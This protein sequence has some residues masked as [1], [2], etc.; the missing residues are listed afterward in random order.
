MKK[1]IIVVTF[2]IISSPAFAQDVNAQITDYFPLDIGN[3]WTYASASGKMAEIIIIR[4]SMDDNVSN[5]GTSIYLFEQ[6][7]VGIGS[8]TTLYS[9]KQ[10]KVVIMVERNIFGQYQ[11]K[12]P[13][14]PVLALAGQEWQYNDR[15]DD[16][17]Y[18]T[19]K[20]SCVFDGK[21]FNDCILV[22][23]QIIEGRNILQ[24]KKSYYAQ[25]VGLVYVTLQGQGEDESVF[26]KLESCNFTNIQE[27]ALPSIQPEENNNAENEVTQEQNDVV[28][29]DRLNVTDSNIEHTVTGKNEN[30]SG[31]Y[32][33]Y[34]YAMN[35]PV[36]I[37]F[38]L[39]YNRFG[40][41]W[42]FGL[43][44][45]AHSDWPTIDDPSSPLEKQEE[46]FMDM[47]WGLYY[48]IINNLFINIGVGFYANTIYGL[49]NVQGETNP[50]WCKIDGR[51]G[52]SLGFALEA[53][54]MYSFK[55]FY[56]SAGYRQYFDESYIPSFYAGAGFP[57]RW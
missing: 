36:G 15:G 12:K 2:L 23:E 54:F 24:V 48:R 16:L 56:L 11:E 29:T 13:P 31:L 46:H 45:S 1:I 53:G 27:E 42:T 47:M 43:G 8:G 4:N 14:F 49:F 51:D 32:I 3:T 55:W 17:R 28:E 41:Y 35:L 22:E 5:D 44:G 40:I 30:T 10:N 33:G 7:F 50:V 19:S 6:Q 38:G 25:G 34:L 37:N 20:S 57:L 52:I 18:R 21:T 26:R 9:I 39:T